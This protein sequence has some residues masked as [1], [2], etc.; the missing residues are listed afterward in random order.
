LSLDPYT[1]ELPVI[2]APMAGGPSTPA[3]AAAVSQA[4]GLGFIAAGYKT[5]EAVAGDIAAYRAATGRPF[6]VNLFA[7]TGRPAEA[8]VIADYAARLRPEADRYDVALGEPRHDDDHYRAKLALI[9]RERVPVASFTFGC[10]AAE[11]V[12]GLQARGTSVWVTVTSVAEAEVAL[13]AGADGLITQGAEAGGHRGFFIDD[14]QHENLGLLVLLQLVSRRVPVPLIAAGGIMDG[15]GLAATLCAG[16]AAAQLG[17]AL[18]LTPE[19]GT[20]PAQREAL[21]AAGPTRLTRAFSGRTARGLVNRF[22]QEHD[23]YAPRAYP[24]IHH[25]TTPVRAAARQAGDAGA[26]NLWAGQGHELARSQPAGELVR[27]LVDE[28]RSVIRGLARGRLA[29]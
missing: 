25:L 9:E 23:A 26:I 19:A 10:P 3:L 7:P 14:D 8:G 15:P 13:A 20:S 22:M 6:G 5:P 24:E 28:A 4:G 11:T 18:M 2:G 16:A 1:L 29:D 21:A 12:A 17:T 27:E